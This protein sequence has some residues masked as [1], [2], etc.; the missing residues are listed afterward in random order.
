M[1]FHIFDTNGW[2]ITPNCSVKFVV[3]L[4]KTTN[5]D[6]FQVVQRL[7]VPAILGCEFKRK[8]VRAIFPQD[9][10]AVLS[11]EETI[12]IAWKDPSSSEC[13]KSSRKRRVRERCKYRDSRILVAKAVL[14]PPDTRRVVWVQSP[15]NSTH[16]LIPRGEITQTKGIA[17]ANGV[18]DI[19]ATHACQ[20]CVTNFSAPSAL[21]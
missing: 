4:C 5:R 1:Q 19:H 3:R 9:A 11:S 18:A 8:H 2:P 12:L 15:C 13:E 7:D 17:L 20:E 21:I 14:M 16:L 10:L 6:T